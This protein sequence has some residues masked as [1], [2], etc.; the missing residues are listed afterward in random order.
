MKDRRIT[1]LGRKALK[2]IAREH[3]VPFDEV[4]Q[5]IQAEIDQVWDNDDLSV[6]VERRKLFP[7]DKPT[8]EE[9]IVKLA[10]QTQK[11]PTM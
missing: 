3:G 11:P 5:E 4:R 8:P 1:A 2:R 9:F 7:N 10:M 6:M